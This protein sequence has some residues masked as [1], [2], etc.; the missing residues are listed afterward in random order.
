MHLVVQRDPATGADSV[1]LTGP[2]FEEDWQNEL[3]TAAA[4]TVHGTFAGAPSLE[5]AVVIARDSMTATERL[6]GVLLARAPAGA[7]ACKA[8]CDHCCYQSVA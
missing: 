5:G 4:N 7:V 1:A 2:V 3:A 8:G 6:I